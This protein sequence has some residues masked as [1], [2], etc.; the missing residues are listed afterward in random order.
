MA[1]GRGAPARLSMAR[2]FVLW[3]ARIVDPDSSARPRSVR[4]RRP[5]GRAIGYLLLFGT[6]AL[7]ANALVGESG[8]LATRMASRQ[9]A[10]LAGQ[11]AALKGQNEGL[12]EHVRRLREDPTFIEEIA[13][14][15]FGLMYPGERVF[16]LR[17]DSP[18][19]SAAAPQ[20][21]P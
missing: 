10:R 9:Q 14:R 2:S 7:V 4:A 11:I 15:E 5:G 17:S 21:G 1:G 12:R 6:C 8:L 3:Y 20:T 18:P 19:A 16:I 13:R